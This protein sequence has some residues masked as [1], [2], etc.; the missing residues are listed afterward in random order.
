VPKGAHLS[1]GTPLSLGRRAVSL[2]QALGGQSRLTNRDQRRRG[3]GCRVREPCERS[4]EGV[5]ARSTLLLS[6]AERLVESRTRLQARLTRSGENTLAQ[7]RTIS[8]HP[9]EPVLALDY[10]PIDDE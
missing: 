8:L 2:P 10:P 6:G 4:S 5:P 9:N 1:R 3:R 7:G